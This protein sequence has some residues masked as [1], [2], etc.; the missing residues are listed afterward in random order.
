M[1]SGRWQVK[2][3]KEKDLLDEIR[4]ERCVIPPSSF[5]RQI[6]IVRSQAHQTATLSPPCS[7]HAPR[8]HGSI[9]VCFNP[10]FPWRTC[11]LAGQRWGNPWKFEGNRRRWGGKWQ[12]GLARQERQGTPPIGGRNHCRGQP[13]QRSL[14]LWR[15]G[16]EWSENINF[17]ATPWWI[18]TGHWGILCALGWSIR[19]PNHVAVDVRC[20]RGRD[21][22]VAMLGMVHDRGWLKLVGR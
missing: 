16:A 10:H 5:V 17:L 9:V 2:H 15:R 1:T 14:C 4:G 18:N 6:N 7:P 11:Y 21:V 13:W 20:V 19:L 8:V 3:M 12:G 22:V